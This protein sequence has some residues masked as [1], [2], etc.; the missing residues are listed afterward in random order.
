MN[1]KVKSLIETMFLSEQC[2][3]SKVITSVRSAVFRPWHMAHNHFATCLLP[4]R[5]HVQSQPR[6]SLLRCV[7]LLLL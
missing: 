3:M 7:K 5:Q 2:A 1:R 6:N 4:C